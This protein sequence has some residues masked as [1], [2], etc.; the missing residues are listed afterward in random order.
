MAA[1]DDDLSK[2]TAL[3][4]D[5]NPNSRAIL[6]AQ[7][8][9]LGLQTVVQST[10]TV[11]AR[12][13]LEMQRF[14]FVLCEMH[15]ADESTSGQELRHDI[16]NSQLLPFQTVFIMITSEANYAKVAEAAE[17]ALDGYLLKPHKASQLA[18]RLQVARMRKLALMHIFDAIDAQQ[19]ERACDL[20]PSALPRAA[21]F[22]CT[23]GGCAPSCCC[24]C[25]ATKRPWR[26]TR[27]PPRKP[28]HHG[29]NW[30]SPAPTWRQVAWGRPPRRWTP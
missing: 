9:D 2:C 8:R 7:M 20:L 30:A 19:F 3:V 14:D 15:F 25:S 12:R 22:G 5:G 26:C 27:L 29:P 11:D 23:Q 16:R 10:R 28:L 17:S 18:E 6:V 1:I 21:C 24:A 13:R 4:V